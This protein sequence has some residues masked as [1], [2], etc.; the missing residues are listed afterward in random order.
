MAY[1]YRRVV[2][3]AMVM[4]NRYHYFHSHELGAVLEHR[5]LVE[6]ITTTCAEVRCPQHRLSV[7]GRPRP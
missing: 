7:P 2:P 5:A 3:A 4:L 1:M 6:I